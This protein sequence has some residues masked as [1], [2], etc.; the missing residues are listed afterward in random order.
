MPGTIHAALG[1]ADRVVNVGAGTGNYEPRDRLVVAVEP[2][3]AMVA[4]RSHRAPGVQGLA[5]A[6]PFPA[7]SFGVAMASLTLHHWSDLGDPAAE[8]KQ[9]RV[10]ARYSS[11]SDWYWFVAV[12]G[13][14]ATRRAISLR[15]SI[16][17]LP[18]GAPVLASDRWQPPT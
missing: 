2:S 1:D 12:Y 4:A 13:A 3:A 9:V 7:A 5:E 17:L 18:T 8:M 15:S 14:A 16:D 11:G 10:I 6:L